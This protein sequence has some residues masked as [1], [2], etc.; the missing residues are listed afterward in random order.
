MSIQASLLGAG[1]AVAGSAASIKK[2]LQQRQEEQLKKIKE[3]KAAQQKQRRN[4]MTYLKKQPTS[5]G[6][7]V[8]ELP[9]KMQKQ[10]ASSYSTAQRKKL[11]DEM[12]R[13]ASKQKEGNK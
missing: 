3:K 6:V 4:F 12:D 7:S 9:E 11:M 2:T 5:L 1:M 8:G 10:I 13:E